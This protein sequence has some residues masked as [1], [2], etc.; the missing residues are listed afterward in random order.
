MSKPS[1]PTRR[2]YPFADAHAYL[3]ISGRT[4]RA[5]M[6]AGAIPFIRVSP[7][8]IAFDLADLDGYIERQRTQQ[9]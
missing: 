6:A 7:R 2:L 3:S 5:L 1:A 4:L 8:R 9:G